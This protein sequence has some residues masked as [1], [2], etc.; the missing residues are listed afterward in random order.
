MIS[1]FRVAAE[2]E[3]HPLKQKVD[4]VFYIMRCSVRAR[5]K[6]DDELG[7]SGRVAVAAAGGRVFYM[8]MV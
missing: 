6:S 3:H 1:K 2:R 4:D 5:I 8:E 7:A